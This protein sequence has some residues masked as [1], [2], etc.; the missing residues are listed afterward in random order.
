MR[1]LRLCYFFPLF[2]SVPA[3]LLWS[4]L[5][6]NGGTNLSDLTAPY[7]CLVAYLLAV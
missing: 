6:V 4:G 7:V 5:C 1:Y 3:H 2:L